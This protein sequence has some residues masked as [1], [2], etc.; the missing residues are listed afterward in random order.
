MNEK[1]MEDKLVKNL[2]KIESGLRL[3]ERQKRIDAGIIDL[4][5]EDKKGRYVIVEVKIRPDTKDSKR[6]LNTTWISR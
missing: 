2:N 5:C 4:F 6:F 3:V 1:E